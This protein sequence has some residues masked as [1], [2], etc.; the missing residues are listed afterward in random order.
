MEI[1]T[2]VRSV[3][4]VSWIY[5]AFQNLMGARQGWLRFVNEHVRP[6]AGDRILDIGC[7]PADI[8][9]YLPEVDYWGFD[10][11]AAYIETAGRKFGGKGTFRCGDLTMEELVQMPKF[12]IV[13]ASGV[14]HHLD[15]VKAEGVFRIAYQALKPGG[16]LATV[17]PCFTAGQNPIARFLIS[18]DRGQNVRS[19]EGYVQLAGRIF[20]DVNIRI[21]HKAW[22]PYTQCYV[23][24]TR[25]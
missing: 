13:T 7:G 6:V 22:I 5:S 17:D 1:S 24:C 4:R 25:T 11:S 2:G 3:L 21:Q 10:V 20:P 18:C 14:L 15:D 12:D 16:R 8:L 23:N 9:D 19:P